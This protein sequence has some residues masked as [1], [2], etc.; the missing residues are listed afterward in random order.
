M[1]ATNPQSQARTALVKGTN[2]QSQA[3]TALVRGTNP[4]GQAP[5]VETRA[6]VSVSQRSAKIAPWW[7]DVLLVAAGAVVYVGILYGHGWLFGMPVAF[8]G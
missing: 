8:S 7:Q 1:R 2:P 4:P 6:E 5:S 3:R